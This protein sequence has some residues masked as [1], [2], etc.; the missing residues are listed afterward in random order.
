M[1]VRKIRGPFTCH[2]GISP[3]VLFQI[4]KYAVYILLSIDI[5]LFL[6]DDWLAS[7]R[8]FAGGVSLGEIVEAFSAT[9]DTAA[10]VMLLLLFELETYVLSEDRI[11]GAL[12]WTLHGVRVF[13]YLFIIWAFYGYCV[14]LGML[15]D[16]APLRLDTLCA[17]ADR[18]WSL[19]V[20]LDEY[21]GIGARNCGALAAAADLYR[22]GDLSIAAHGDTLEAARWLAWTDV[23][24]AG[25][26][27]LVVI[28]LE[29]DVWLQEAQ[30][31]E[32]V[33]FR[34]S[35]AIK[36]LLYSIL[37]AAAVYWGIAGDFLDF[38]DAFLWLLAFAFI[39]MNVLDWHQEHH[40]PSQAG[41]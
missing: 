38:W 13:C 32:G 2:G 39:E 27:L 36:F 4:F 9:V 6:R 21:V 30:K 35:Y 12:K 15:Y 18:G 41:A 26:W 25:T 34:V 1:A 19:L 23:I 40:A 20:D 5:F 22:I 37:L 3:R 28:I 7:D 8:T 33:I 17:L 10:W 31:F 14:K 29:S 11:R 16:A 24:N